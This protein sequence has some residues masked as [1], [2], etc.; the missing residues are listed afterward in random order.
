MLN[1]FTARGFPDPERKPPVEG[2]DLF[3]WYTGAF[4]ILG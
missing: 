1:F 2:R 4:P 3:V